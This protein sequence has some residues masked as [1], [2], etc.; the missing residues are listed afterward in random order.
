[1]K[2]MHKTLPN[3]T[4]HKTGINLFLHNPTA[5]LE[6]PITQ[7]LL[8]QIL[9]DL[10]LEACR[11]HHLRT[12]IHHPCRVHLQTQGNLDTSELL[13]VLPPQVHH[14]G[15]LLGEAEAEVVGAAAEVEVEEEVAV[16][17]EED[18]ET[19]G[20]HCNHLQC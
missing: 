1:M 17:E 11:L 4:F 10:L 14:D 7:T 18:T 3:Q 16:E 9:L 20:I 2:G 13:G 8:T 5:L 19:Q 12:V 6:T 15:L